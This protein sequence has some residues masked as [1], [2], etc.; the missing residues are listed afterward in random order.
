MFKKTNKINKN[1]KLDTYDKVIKF[2]N[3]KKL[4]LQS[5][6]FIY[7]RVVKVVSF[8]SYFVFYEF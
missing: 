2:N 6:E 3:Y 4:E 5:W 8:N 7:Q 1:R